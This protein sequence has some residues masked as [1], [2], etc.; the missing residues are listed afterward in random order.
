MTLFLPSVVVKHK[1]SINKK[2][3]LHESVRGVPPVPYPV[4]GMSCWGR[5]VPLS[6][7]WP[8]GEG[9]PVLVLARGVPQSAPDLGPDLGTSPQ[10]PAPGQ[11]QDRGTPSLPQR[12]PGTRVWEGT[13]DLRLW[14]PPERTRE[15][16][17]RRD[18]G[19]KAGTCENITS[20]HNIMYV[21]GNKVLFPWLKC[22]KGTLLLPMAV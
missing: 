16:K 19:P 12:G 7:S 4:H 17:L 9:T 5:G 2:V 20:R 8:V 15:Q 21:G 10:S 1:N 22:K 6:C 14:Y 11:D 3:L 18:L 13:W